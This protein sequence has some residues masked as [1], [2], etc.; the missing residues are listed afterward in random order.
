[1]RPLNFGALDGIDNPNLYFQP[2]Q[3]IC[4][5]KPSIEKYKEYNHVFESPEIKEED[6]FLKMTV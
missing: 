1:M 3:I 2:N 6:E 4:L 5:C